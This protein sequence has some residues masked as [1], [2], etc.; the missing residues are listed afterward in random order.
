VIQTA[1]AVGLA[2]YLAVLLFGHE[3]PVFAS[4]AALVALG[5]TVG[6]Q[7]SRAVQVV[8]GVASG[9]AI[10][11]LLALAVGTGPAQM[12]LAVGLALAMAVF[13][14][15][16]PLLVMQVGISSI[17]AVGVEA[18][19]GGFF[20]PERFLDALVGGGVAMAINLLFPVNPE[21]RVEES[22]R[23]IFDDL[24]GTLEQT[25][26]ALEGGDLEGA[27][28]ALR[29]AREVDDRVDDFR[30]N[31][32]AAGET[33]RLSPARRPATG[34]LEFYEAAA[35]D[36]DL[37]APNARVLARA[38]LR[39]LRE[40]DPAAPRAPLA[41]AV[42]DLSRAVK[43]LGCYLEEKGRPPD[44]ARRFALW[45]AADSTAL[46]EEHHDLATNAL[47]AQIRST[48]VDLLKGTGMGYD[49][50]LAAVEEAVRS[51]ATEGRTAHHRNENG[52]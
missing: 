7:W 33:A 34:H 52:P 47:V 42:A 24:A 12:A 50:A 38:A 32:E 10:A 11:N 13:L 2:W 18:S 5:V 51:R 17:I 21:R 28:E 26:R 16:G 44:E 49:E 6:R 31:L 15:A 37:A 9:I 48:A 41:E 8:L 45:A 25:A 46:L 40:D 35:D 27:A 20:S 39:L 4:V 22:A 19:S 36:L 29:K 30:E 14:G 3:R 43:A 1:V 23:P